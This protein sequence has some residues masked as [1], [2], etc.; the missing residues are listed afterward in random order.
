MVRNSS[1]SRKQFAKYPNL[2][3]VDNY[4]YS[5]KIKSFINRND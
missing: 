5:F 3:L 2:L 4:A 1:E